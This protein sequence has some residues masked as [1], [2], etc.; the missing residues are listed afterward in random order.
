MYELSNERL[1]QING[2]SALNRIIYALLG[3]AGMKLIR[4]SRGYL[5]FGR[6]TWMK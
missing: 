1:Q 2:G 5:R 6:I 3:I 4:A